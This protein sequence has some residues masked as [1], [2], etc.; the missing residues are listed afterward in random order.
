VS[1]AIDV[2]RIPLSPAAATLLERHVVDIETLLSGGDD[3]EILC[4]IPEDRFEAFALAA[5][6]AGVAVTSIGAIVAG[7]ATPVFLDAEGRQLALKRLS[8]SHF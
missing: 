7:V 6:Q 8:Y 4:T 2:A 1:A 3:Y 5:R